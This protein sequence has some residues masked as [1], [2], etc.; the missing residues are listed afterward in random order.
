M[1]WKSKTVHYNFG[2]HQI[3]NKKQKQFLQEKHNQFQGELHTNCSNF[4][5][6]DTFHNSFY[7][8]SAISLIIKAVK[9]C[10]TWFKQILI[11]GNDDHNEWYLTIHICIVKTTKACQVYTLLN[12]LIT[13]TLRVWTYSYYIWMKWIIK[14]NRYLCW[15]TKICYSTTSQRMSH[16]IV[17]HAL[18]SIIM[19][20]KR[21][22]KPT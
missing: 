6:P 17:S 15:L 8:S 14:R 5:F 12:T 21:Q 9:V 13:I 16:W 19:S 11:T 3:K 1:T 22:A 4:Q 7:H 2:K 20:E 18:D 10:I